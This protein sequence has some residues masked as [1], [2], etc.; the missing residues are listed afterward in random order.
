MFVPLPVLIGLAAALLLLLVLLARSMRRGGDADLAD[1]ARDLA[2]RRAASA[3]AEVP[4][5]LAAQLRALLAAR[6]KI[7]AIKELREATGMG[8]KDAKDFV[9]R[10]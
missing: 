3:G 2:Q 1:I 9:E 5:E 8:L 7:G 4:P 6:D 10:L